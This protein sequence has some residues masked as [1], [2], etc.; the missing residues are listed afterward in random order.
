MWSVTAMREKVK[1]FLSRARRYP[2]HFI[3]RLLPAAPRRPVPMKPVSF[4]IIAQ[5]KLGDA[6]LLLPL[7]RRLKEVFPEAV[8]SVLASAANQGVFKTV[9]WVDHV[10][11]YR[12]FS[13][14][15]FL[16]MRNRRFDVYYNPK[17]HPSWTFLLCTVLIR[18]EL[19]AGYD[20]PLL[21]RFF[22][23][24]VA[25]S[26]DYI[27]DRNGAL[28]SLWNETVAENPMDLGGYCTGE[29]SV[30][31]PGGPMSGTVVGI[32]LSA[33]EPEREWGADQA[34]ALACMLLKHGIG[35]VLIGMKNKSE[36]IDSIC[37]RNEGAVPCHSL[38]D[39]WDLAAA[40]ARLDC[41]VTPDTATLHLAGLQGVPVVALFQNRTGNFKRFFKPGERSRAVVS[42]GLRVRDIQAGTVLAPVMDLI[43]K[44]DA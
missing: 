32:N 22:H 14:Q 30:N 41:L 17:D 15:S 34:E 13:Y 8:I 29:S 18:A 28:L 20:H 36:E 9:E 25:C 23:R 27:E 3:L 42:P 1:S 31:T 33:G 10:R 24:T 37:S 6:I 7:L 16:W 19:K 26:S 12:P 2:L 38:V 5:E 43:G 11:L 39:V 35:I 4:C 44:N 21:R 40:V